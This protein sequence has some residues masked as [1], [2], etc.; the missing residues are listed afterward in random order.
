MS[1]PAIRAEGLWK[2]YLVGAQASNHTFREALQHGARGALRRLAGGRA[3]RPAT[4]SFWALRDVSFDIAHGDVV[5]IIGRNGAGKSTLLKVLSRITAPTRGRVVVNG[6]IASLLEVGTGFHPELTG[7]ENIRLNGAILGMTGAEISRKFDE[8][9]DFSGVEKFLDTP[10]KRYSSGM[11]V[12]LAFAVAAHLDPEILVIDE[13]LAVGDAEFQ[14]KCMGKMGELATRGEG[15]TILFVS[16]NLSAVTALCR[17]AI[18]LGQGSVLRAGPVYDVVQEY[19]RTSSASGQYER[20]APPASDA[21]LLTA[22]ITYESA[23]EGRESSVFSDLRVLARRD[24]PTGLCLRVKDS[25][26][27]VVGVASVGFT[28]LSTLVQLRAGVN[29]IRLRLPTPRLAA[30]DYSISIDV[31]HTGVSHYDRVEDCLT[32]SVEP[33]GGEVG[34]TPLAQAW[35]CGCVYFPTELDGEPVVEPETMS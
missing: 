33:T 25:F 16:H 13:V 34:V 35:N 28:D 26:G 15:R 18:Y 19:S 17:S 3:N 12:R 7:R 23:R 14:K 6:R 29:A 2:E 32:L 30:G 31:T 24:M 20:A 8:I 9:V 27:G 4:N 1:G 10:V 5:G 22:N 11:Q 21:T